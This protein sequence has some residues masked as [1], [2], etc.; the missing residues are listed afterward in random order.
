[1]V[2]DVDK[3]KRRISLG[4]K[5]APGNPWELFLEAYPPGTEIEGEIRNI[6]EF[7]LFIALPA[8]GLGGLVS[9]LRKSSVS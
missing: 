8:G 5:Q 2:L 7:G 6:T 3:A 4:M 9:P 1:M